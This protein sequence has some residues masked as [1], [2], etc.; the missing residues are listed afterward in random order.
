MK[1]TVQMEC[2]GIPKQYGLPKKLRGKKTWKIG[3]GCPSGLAVWG[4]LLALHMAKKVCKG[5]LGLRKKQKGCSGHAKRQKKD[6]D[7][8]KEKNK[9]KTKKE[10]VPKPA[11]KAGH[12]GGKRDAT[13]RK[14]RC[15]A[16]SVSLGGMALALFLSG[17]SAIPGYTEPEDQYIVSALGFDVRDGFLSVTARVDRADGAKP[18]VFEGQGKN[19]EYAI[20]HL[21]G[22]DEKRLET[23]HCALLVI[24][25]GVTP[26][27]LAEILSY[28]G[29]NDNITVAA[30]VAA[31]F[32][33]GAL[34]R[35]ES[36]SGY[37]LI[38]ALRAKGDGTGLGEES[39]FYEIEEARATK[40]S[41]A[42]PYFYISEEETGL[43]GLKVYADDA[44][45]CILDRRESAFFRILCG[46]FRQGRIDYDTKHGIGSAHV[47]FC[48][49]Q[50]SAEPS[51]NGILRIGV[52]CDL[53][54]DGKQP[55][56]GE[57]D[58]ETLSATLAGEMQTLYQQLASR[59][60]D[61]FGLAAHV[62][63]VLPHAADRWA[64]SPE[65][66][67]EPVEVFFVCRLEKKPA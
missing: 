36:G 41:F 26:S 21:G 19:V 24:G 58:V 35:T 1:L 53:W 67:T 25:A 52:W 49:T 45:T 60:G 31:A 39:R 29:R 32:D 13:G 62:E 43:F 2:R 66:G 8:D 15:F 38:G 9:T 40:G 5:C 7:K 6:K 44:E 51:D 4:G 37:R 50:F 42:L 17:C 11:F 18:L 3:D 61:V 30:H 16:V 47:L 65:Q 64:L 23:G 10:K 48:R 20:S 28:C 27:Y 33:A 34:L 63:R 56:T 12:S 59:Y 22:S 54:L 55:M 57:E 46:K 14:G